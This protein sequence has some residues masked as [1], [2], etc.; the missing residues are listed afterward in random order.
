MQALDDILGRSYND[1]V[2]LVYECVEE[3]LVDRAA[4]KV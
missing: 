4:P 1:V 3:I 2:N